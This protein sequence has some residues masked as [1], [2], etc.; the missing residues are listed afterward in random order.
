VDGGH[1]ST[2]CLA[3]TNYEKW[4]PEDGL[5]DQVVNEARHL[6]GLILD[7]ASR[8]RGGGGKQKWALIKSAGASSTSSA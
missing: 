4:N 8:L 7:E 1:A 6:G 3:I 2:P 5:A